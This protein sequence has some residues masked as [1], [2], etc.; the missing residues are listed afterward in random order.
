MWFLFPNELR[1]RC[2]KN[3]ARD[4][5][6]IYAPISPSTRSHFSATA[7]EE[8]F[9]QEIVTQNSGLDLIFYS[10]SLYERFR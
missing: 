2:S 4:R 5:S 7:T 8:V 9:R 10:T 6:C 3:N 1:T